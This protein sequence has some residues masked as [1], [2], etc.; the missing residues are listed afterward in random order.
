[1]KQMTPRERKLVALAILAAILAGLWFAILDP[2]AGGYLRRQDERERL[3]AQM[4]IDNRLVANL[5]GWKAAAEE[6][7]RTAGDFTLI[8][9]TAALATEALK[10]KVIAI[11]SA[12]GA[13]VRQSQAVTDGVTDHWVR[14]RTDL[15]LTHRQFHGCLRRLASEAPYVVIDFLSVVADQS[16]TKGRLEPLD[17]SLVVS[18]DIRT[19]Q[20][21][22]RSALAPPA[23][24]RG[25]GRP[26][27]RPGGDVPRHGPNDA[28]P[29]SPRHRSAAAA[30][31][32]SPRRIAV[33]RP[34]AVFPG[35]P[36]G[37]GGG[38]RDRV[39]GIRR[40]GHRR[41]DP[42]GLG[43]G[44]L[45]RWQGDPSAS[46]PDDRGVDGA[47][48]RPPAR[49]P[50]PGG[51]K[52]GPDARPEG[53]PLFGQGQREKQRKFLMD[54]RRAVCRLSGLALLSLLVVGC[55]GERFETRDSPP[56]PPRLQESGPAPDRPTREPPTSDRPA[57]A[58]PHV[59]IRQGTQRFIAPPRPH[60]EARRDGDGTVSLNF[61]NVD[62][63]DA[64]KAVLGDILGLDYVVE[65]SV[66]GTVTVETAQPVAPAEILPA[67]E[68]G[69]RAAGMGL[70]KRAGG[71]AVVPL[72]EARRQPALVGSQSPG[73]GTEAVTLRY[74]GAAQ[75]K[76]LFDP[77][78]PE[79]AIQAD[80]SRNVLL[81]TGSGADRVSLRAMVEQFDVNWLHGMSFA[82]ITVQR[83]DSRRLVEELNQIINAEGS[84]S[85]GLV[86]LI[87]M[88][89]LNGIVAIS[90]Q[91]H[92][93]DDV[94]YWA[95][96]LDRE[97][98]GG[99]RR[100]FVYR[101]QNGRASNLA[102]VLG[103]IFGA[104]GSGEGG[105]TAAAGGTSL[106]R[107]IATAVNANAAPTA[108]AT[109]SPLAATG[110]APALATGPAAGLGP[111]QQLRM[112]EAGRTISVTSDDTNNA[113]VIY[114]TSREYDLVEQALRKLDT[115]PLQVLIEAV[116]TEVTLNDSLRFGVEWYFK[117]GASNFSLTSGKTLLPV[118]SFP[119][120]SY[121][122][123]QGDGIRTVINALDKVTT[124]NVVSSPQLL[125]LNN[126]TASLQVGD[127]VPVATQSS[128]STTT[129]NAPV[130]N[131][132]EYRDTGVILKVTPRVNDSGLV[133][134]DIAQEVSDVATTTSST[135]DSPT[136]QQR[137]VSSSVAVQDGQTVALGGLIRDNLS[138][139]SS[140]IPLLADIPYLGSLFGA[141][142]NSR[143]R[144]ELL[145][146][147]TP[148]VVRS[149]AEAQAV[150]D[151][152]RRKIST[153][154]PIPIP[155][156]PPR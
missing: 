128:V 110:P 104:A 50:R 27:R 47:A 60:A 85:A 109:A 71:Y 13:T 29:R 114:A 111:V 152:L 10:E 43:G 53:A 62:I 98:E 87:A 156:A 16:A 116:I 140:G 100:L 51:R 139:G 79:N 91:P 30:T 26:S 65:A 44:A 34:S 86:R 148:R 58:A 39:G 31:V 3:T 155:K 77:I 72:A 45:P 125:V 57:A 20:D 134:L 89:R 106:P 129:A 1:M 99:E 41:F 133:L 95:E 112:G 153:I 24:Q 131:S 142:D 48:D 151:E 40:H 108:M 59:E 76:K 117:T 150:T 93:L 113:I 64:A 143:V 115:L 19:G 126:Q 36:T 119:G 144:T 141:T 6:Q 28:A 11:A 107:A 136:I 122:L 5:P 7:S 52:P 75:L 2:L 145:V 78:V 147:L 132:I 18:A 12:E 63:R 14:V 82:L 4:A 68:N 74:V 105:G 21:Q 123:A 149:S 38:R 83:A 54:R 135:L 94:R 55:S 67:F 25:D 92:Y 120:F 9:P 118:Q 130:V 22:A 81:L 42:G 84:P 146:L 66:Q 102:A 154:E 70:V 17:V 73:F 33:S 32:R 138:R 101:V 56:P 23:G 61:V 49:D 35:S 96:E 97:G 69:L 103:N 37:P 90:P 88:T 80:P 124:I 15:R 121:L 137:R 8:A 127:Q 46:R